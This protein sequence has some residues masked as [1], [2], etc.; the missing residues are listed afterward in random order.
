MISICTESYRSMETFHVSDTQDHI[1]ESQARTEKEIQKLE[2]IL[3]AMQFKLSAIENHISGFDGESQEHTLVESLR[4]PEGFEFNHEQYLA[5]YARH[6]LDSG[7]QFEKEVKKEAQTVYGSDIGSQC[8]TIQK[9]RDEVAEE[10]SPDEAIDMTTP[11]QSPSSSV[12][13]QEIKAEVVA[14]FSK[15]PNFIRKRVDLF[16]KEVSRQEA[17]GAFEEARENQLKSI[18]LLE[19]LEQTHSLKFE[20]RIPFVRRLAHLY[21]QDDTLGSYDEAANIIQS[22]QQHVAGDNQEL[23]SELHQMLAVVYVGKKDW[24]H[25][26][27]HGGIALDQREKLPG[28]PTALVRESAEFLIK[29]YE[30]QNDTDSASFAFA[31]RESYGKYLAY[32]S[33]PDVRG[34]RENFRSVSG[35][36]IE[37]QATLSPEMSWLVNHGFDIRPREYK[38]LPHKTTKLTPIIT[39]IQSNDTAEFELLRR[40]IDDGASVNAKDG[41][42][43]VKMTP[44]MWAVRSK[45]EAAMKLLLKARADTREVDARGRTALHIAVDKDSTSYAQ[46]LYEYDAEMI[47]DADN[48]GTTPLHCGVERKSK[49]MV[50]WLLNR[51]ADIDAQDNDGQTPMHTAVYN[52]AVDMITQLL[53]HRPSPDLTLRNGEGRTAIETAKAKGKNSRLYHLLSHASRSPISSPHPQLHRSSTTT[54]VPPQRSTTTLAPDSPSR[55]STHTFRDKPLPASPIERRSTSSSTETRNLGFFPAK[56]KAKHLPTKG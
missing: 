8:G 37:K 33:S 34:Q 52:D 40:F 6:L 25:A 18:A 26:E 31:L 17:A 53:N 7:R 32:S 10:A 20:E 44:I 24:K 21:M 48:F 27:R 9:W 56:W 43:D 4:G 36:S 49:K 35:A 5:K 23:T 29:L 45:N 28:P 19:E 42:D 13:S 50:T 47:H 51:K 38:D 46:R 30:T 3:R 54:L 14:N 15:T 16:Q 41:D 11:T 2:P 12:P 1:E 22:L 39:L 55:S